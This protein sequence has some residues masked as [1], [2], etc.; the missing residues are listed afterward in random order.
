MTGDCK[1]DVGNG[2]LYKLYN[3]SFIRKGS[4]DTGS[5]LSIPEFFNSVAAIDPFMM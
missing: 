4:E 2:A 1:Q 3:N 5:T